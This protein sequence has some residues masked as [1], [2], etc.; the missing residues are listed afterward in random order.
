MKQSDGRSVA[1]AVGGVLIALVGLGLLLAF[2]FALQR[3]TESG[4]VE[5]QLGSRTFDAGSAEQRA[6]S[7][8]REGPILLPD[9]ASGQRDIYLQ[10][11][12]DDAQDGWLAFDAREIDATRECTLRWDAARGLFEDPCDGS[13][14]PADGEGLRHYPVVVDDAG[15]L[16]IDLNRAPETGNDTAP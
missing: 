10:H 11:L 13:T 15:K 9:P 8:A 3:G 12:G 2:V 16:V 5:V 6:A 14:V 7:I 4:K 1:M